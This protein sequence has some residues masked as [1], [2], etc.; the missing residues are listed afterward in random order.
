M[1]DYEGLLKLFNTFMSNI[2]SKIDKTNQLL[3]ALSEKFDDFTNKT[4]VPH[5]LLKETSDVLTQV[6]QEL[7]EFNAL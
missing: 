3:Q 4:S 1:N 6:K 5:E 2:T 7:H